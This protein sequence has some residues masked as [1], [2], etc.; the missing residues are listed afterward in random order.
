MLHLN[1]LLLPFLLLA[2]DPAPKPEKPD[3]V[4]LHFNDFHGQVLPRVVQQTA[5]GDENGKQVRMGGFATLQR[6]VEQQRQELGEARVWVTE[7]GDWYQGTPEG[8]E[9][10]G[11]SIIECFNR[12]RLTVSQIGNHEFD[13]G[14][15]NVARLVPLAKYPI[16]GAN[17]L[18]AKRPGQVRQYAKPFIVLEKAG[19]R[20]AIVGLV[21]KDT[22]GVS[23][24]PF[25]DAEFQDEARTLEGLL[26]S[27]RKEAD[28]IVLLTHCGLETDKALAKRFPELALI[29]GGHSHTELRRQER[30]GSTVIVQSGS[31]GS[32][33][34]R[35]EVDLAEQ[36]PNF[37]VL[38]TRF[39]EMRTDEIGIDP[40][41]EKFVAERFGAISARWDEPIGSF[42]GDLGRGRDRGPF[43]TAGGNLIAGIIREAG[44]AQVGLTNKG[45]IRTQVHLGPVTRRQIY[46]LV[47]FEN[48]VV[49]FEMTG[50]L[51]RQVLT[52][53][54]ARGR[55]PLEIAGATYTYRVVSGERELVEVKVGD[56]LV[57]PAAT[58][59]V[60]ANSFLAG[61][62]DGFQAFRDA[63]RLPP[64]SR[65]DRFL[66]DILIDKM[67]REK[68]LQLTGEDRIQ[69]VD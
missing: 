19:V 55:R 31:K 66:R 4:V 60:A 52:Q 10:K 40:A 59:R 20:V 49:T 38:G 41:A 57:D 62:G 12:L 58:Y 45:G 44:E 64:T 21:T 43:S 54:L 11:A 7:A 5:R 30:E 42:A 28:A 65:S 61:G 63:R 22:K 36:A 14:E 50:T 33:V 48:T 46:E 17:I 2:Q 69:V 29:L 9:D 24:G 51:L 16:L 26:P 56:Q 67:L 8:N 25:G 34:T 53:S 35:I 27:V 39:V 6:Y 3:L 32:A 1:H 47:P 37:R 23:T 13:F 68:T 15:D 18:D